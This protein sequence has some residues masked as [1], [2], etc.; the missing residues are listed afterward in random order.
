MLSKRRVVPCFL[1]LKLLPLLVN[2]MPLWNHLIFIW[3][4]VQPLILSVLQWKRCLWSS[5]TVA[6]SGDFLNFTSVEKKNT[7]LKLKEGTDMVYDN[8]F[9]YYIYFHTQKSLNRFFDKKVCFFLIPVCWFYQKMN[10]NLL[11]NTEHQ[12]FVIF[13]Y[14]FWSSGGVYHKY[15]QRL[16]NDPE[17]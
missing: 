1:I 16:I 2:L 10:K 15:F 7:I 11:E 8:K 6:F 14:W 13:F 9:F 3:F 17:L 5:S 12:T 4:L